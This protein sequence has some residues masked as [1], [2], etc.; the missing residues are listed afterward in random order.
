L[1]ETGQPNTLNPYTYA[2]GNPTNLADPSGLS[3]SGV[4]YGLQKQNYLLNQQV[5]ALQGVIKQLNSNI[6]GLQG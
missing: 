4:T 5:K 3:A 6:E 1:Y 2:S